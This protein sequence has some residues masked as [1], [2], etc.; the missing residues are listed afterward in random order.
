MTEDLWTVLVG[1]GATS[2]GMLLVLVGLRWHTR[3]AP[4]RELQ[5]HNKAL[6][7]ALELMVVHNPLPP[8]P[9]S[10]M[11]NLRYEAG[12]EALRVLRDHS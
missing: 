9:S 2:M 1:A 6:K 4:F 11:R 12:S 5:D 7:V 8:P 10:G 3:A